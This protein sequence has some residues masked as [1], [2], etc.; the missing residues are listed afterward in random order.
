MIGS[1]VT[2]S[3]AVMSAVQLIARSLDFIAIIVIARFLTPEDFGLVALASSVLLV[4]NSLTELPVSDALVQ[5]DKLEKSAIDSA[6]TLTV[7][8]GILIASVLL[9]LAIPLANLLDDQR[10]RLVICA[11]AIGPLVQGFASPR[12]VNFLREVNYTPLALTQVIGR[13]AAFICVL[14]LAYYTRSYWALVGGL[15][16]GPAITAI[17]THFWAPYR[18]RFAMT[19]IPSLL[20]FAGWVTLSRMIFTLNTQSDRFFVGSILGKAPLGHY[21]MAGDVSSMATYTVATPLMQT[22]FA[23]FSRMQDDMDRLRAA[24]LKGQQIMVTLVAPL[25]FGLAAVATP[26]VSLVFGEKWLPIVP[27]IWWLGP[28]I[29]LQMLTVP[30]QSLA[31]ACGQPRMLVVREIASLALR[32]PTT[33][34]AAWAF[35]LV[36]AAATRSIASTILILLNLALA[37]QLLGTGIWTQLRSCGRAIFASVT[38]AACVV[39]LELTWPAT[40][41]LLPDIVRLTTLLIVGGIVYSVTLFAQWFAAR[42]PAGAEEW[43]LAQITAVT[44]KLRLRMTRRSHLS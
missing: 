6:F 3:A 23:G 11:L 15:V 35:G 28:A 32:L 37:R 31:L 24:Y 22:L 40:G 38:M 1:K 4:A 21:A 41:D 10:L 14:A 43:I 17:I 26:V 18:P 39:L 9:L 34:I 33:I 27:L 2:K 44:N 12:M 25:G 13:M 5:R 36:A 30:V 20:N 29:A 8:R 7:M 19:D 16:A 42:R